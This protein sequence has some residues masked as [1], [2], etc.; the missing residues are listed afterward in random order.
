MKA[1]GRTV[2]SG[3]SSSRCDRGDG[4]WYS[5]IEFVDEIVSCRQITVH[6]LTLHD[7]RTIRELGGSDIYVSF[8]YLDEKLKTS[9]HQLRCVM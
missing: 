6:D 7:K 1:R 2:S 8:K 4:E 5:I 9:E 3:T